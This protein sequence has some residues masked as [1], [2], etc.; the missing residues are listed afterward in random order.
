MWRLKVLCLDYWYSLCPHY[1]GY[2][3]KSVDTDTHPAETTGI[4]SDAPS[5]SNQ[6]S[7]SIHPAACCPQRDT[8]NGTV[9]KRRVSCPRS[10]SVLRGGVAEEGASCRNHSTSQS[11]ELSADLQD[12]Q[13]EV[14]ERK[15]GGHYVS[16][17][18]ATTIQAAYRQYQ[19]QRQF[20]RLRDSVCEN[21][22][23]KGIG[24]RM[25]LPAEASERPTA[26]QVHDEGTIFATAGERAVVVT[27][28]TARQQ[29]CVAGESGASRDALLELETA[30]TEQVRSLAASIDDALAGQS[31]DG[32]GTRVGDD[33][34][35]SSYSDVTLFIDEDA[36]TPPSAAGQSTARST[37]GATAPSTSSTK[38]L[39]AVVKSQGDTGLPD[40]KDPAFS[41][42]D[43]PP[44]PASTDEA[45]LGRAT[46]SSGAARV[47]GGGIGQQGHADSDVSDNESANSTSNSNETIN[48]SSETS[49]HDGATRDAGLVRPG[50]HKDAQGGCD[51]P[52]FSNDI[53]RKRQYRIGLNFFNKKPDRGVAYLV[54]RGFVP[55]TPVGVAHFL[56]QRKGLSRQMIGE[57]LGNRQ[58]TFN[59]DVLE[60]VVDEMDFSG[61][62]LDEALRMFQA[63]IRVQGEAQK[64]ERLIEAFSQRY[65]ICNPGMVKDFQNPDTIFILAFAVVLLN[66]DMYSPNVKPE[67]KMKLEDFVKNLR[68]VD[69][70]A[71]IPRHVLVGIYERIRRNE[72]RT[73]DDHTSQVANVEK[74]ITGKKPVLCLPHRR[75]VCYC[76][77]YEVPEPSR[78]QR[79]GL[80]Q[81][82]VFLFNDL[83][84]VT[85]IMHKKK[86]VMMYSFRRSFSLY[87][88]QVHLFENPCY[89]NGMRLLSALPGADTELLTTYNAANAEDRKKI[90]EDLQEC[91]AE[92]H[93]ME[94]YRI[95]VELEKQKGIVGRQPQGQG[96]AGKVDGTNGSAR[97]RGSLDDS[98][99]IGEG[100]K[101]TALSNSL[102]DL[103]GEGK[104]GRHVTT[105]IPEGHSENTTSATSSHQKL[106]TCESERSSPLQ[107]SNSSSLQITDF[108]RKPPSRTYSQASDFG[109]PEYFPLPSINSRPPSP[110]PAEWCRPQ[111]STQKNQW[112]LVPTRVSLDLR[113]PAPPPVS[114]KPKY[115]GHA[116]S[117]ASCGLPLPYA[118]SVTLPHTPQSGGIWKE[119]LQT[120]PEPSSPSLQKH[121]SVASKSNTLPR[122]KH[123]EQPR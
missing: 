42:L 77:L 13:V 74:T 65:C 64:V 119:N 14:L 59:H 32:V 29:T 49:S 70:G 113:P 71:D 97:P 73:N 75:L 53:S 31:C 87:G 81:R 104:R 27:M 92:V 102:R 48:F 12:K 10:S 30:F 99:I 24:M 35:A 122:L 50:Y 63:H 109:H 123:P 94:K 69:D 76:R 84:V 45:A 39:R 108:G 115:F 47:N 11:Y 18:A 55:D 25:Q 107:V 44:S 54:E 88:M 60:C 72:L 100:L 103:S 16:R 85:K 9:V 15:Y 86:H 96:L 101:R 110:G 21:R 61:M 106:S 116:T 56:L 6:D 51:S 82:E 90:V 40:L 43:D 28:V 66:T 1:K 68:G 111:I 62:E 20:R 4:C 52:A 98:C 95:E 83:L 93:E 5:A 26:A 17:R 41:Q 19:M 118:G 58:R 78:P 105:H 34:L 23:S 38:P 37:T 117:S 91:I 114:S 120:P 121:H 8:P 79:L 46:P 112:P 22:V 36:I 7:S 57:Y 67:R 33:G 2:L 80:H 89:Q 3:A